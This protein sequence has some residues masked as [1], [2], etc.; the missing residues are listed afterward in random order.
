MCICLFQPA[1]LAAMEPTAS[2]LATAMGDPIAI[3]S[4]AL[5]SVLLVTMV[6]AAGKVHTLGHT[7]LYS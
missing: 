5:A 3:M 2:S 4:Q 7:V 6:M 1:L